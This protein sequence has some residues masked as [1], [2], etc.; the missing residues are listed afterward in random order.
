M[1]YCRFIKDH[2]TELQD[3]F[4]LDPYL[5]CSLLYVCPR[6]ELPLLCSYVPLG[7][8][9]GIMGRNIPNHTASIESWKQTEVSLNLFI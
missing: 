3:L 6:R 2:I 1:T 8:M 4:S 9:F 7:L 5:I